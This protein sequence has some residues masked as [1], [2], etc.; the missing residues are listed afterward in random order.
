MKDEN[1]LL[2]VKYEKK[3]NTIPSKHVW[4]VEIEANSRR[5]RIAIYELRRNRKI[6]EFKNVNKLINKKNEISSDCSHDDVLLLK[7]KHENEL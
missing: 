2:R 3:N 6:I 1:H 4:G 5:K 7:N